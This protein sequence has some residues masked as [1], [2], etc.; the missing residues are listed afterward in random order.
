[1]IPEGVNDLEAVLNHHIADIKKSFRNKV[2]RI[3]GQTPAKVASIL[4][5]MDKDSDRQLFTAMDRDTFL[6]IAGQDSDESRD[7]LL[8]GNMAAIAK[9][10]KIAVDAKPLVAL[11]T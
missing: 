9:A 11:P 10:K 6:N 3:A 7:F 5:E 4:V 1:M 2:V 8:K